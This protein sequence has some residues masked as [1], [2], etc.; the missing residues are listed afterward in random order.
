MKAILIDARNNQIKQVEVDDKSFLTDCYKH[1]GCDMIEVAMEVNGN[2]IYVD[3]EGLCKE[4]E[5]AFVVKGGHQ[6]FA[7]NG[8]IV[9]YNAKK[10]KNVDCTLTL[11]EVKKMVSIGRF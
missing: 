3:E 9:G 7:G 2:T 11:A 10:G 8:L 5:C 4:L 6:P 1:I